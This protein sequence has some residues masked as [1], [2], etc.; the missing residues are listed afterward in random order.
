MNTAMTPLSPTGRE[1]WLPTLQLSMQE[2]FRL[3]LGYTLEV[4]AEPPVEEGLDITSMVGLAGQLC[5]ILTVRCS[6][7]SAAHMAS[8]MLGIDPEKAGPEMWDAV[9]EI[10]NMVAGNFKNKISGLGDGC[11]LSVPTVITGADYN[12]RSMVNETL[13]T[14][15][16][17]EG[18]PV[19]VCLEVHN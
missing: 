15:F 12:V 18:E 19:L 14:A 17:F 8:R 10:C 2:V 5:G 4:A 3:M 11:M 7:K 13:Q 6:A 9:G 16:I 1:C